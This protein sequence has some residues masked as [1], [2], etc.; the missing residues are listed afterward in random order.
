MMR[1]KAPF[2]RI[3][4]RGLQQRAPVL[5]SNHHYYAHENGNGGETASESAK[6]VCVS[7]GCDD[8]QWY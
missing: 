2:Q 8:V 3:G 6:A 5:C 1:S 7:N 4:G